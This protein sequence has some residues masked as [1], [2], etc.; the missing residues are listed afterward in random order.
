MVCLIKPQFEAGKEKVGKKGVVER[1]MQDEVAA[2]IR[3]KEEEA[4]DK[5]SENA[6]EI[7]ATAIQRYSQDETIDR[8]V[9][10]VALPSEEMKG[11]IIGREGRNIRAIREFIINLKKRQSL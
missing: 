3:E 4:K 2:F 6:R 10:V 9:S 5:A 11:R 8:T 7:I 1:K